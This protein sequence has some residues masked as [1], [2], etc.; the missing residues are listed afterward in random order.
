[1]RDAAI[2]FA[3]SAEYSQYFPHTKNLGQSALIEPRLRILFCL[4][5]LSFYRL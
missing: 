5:Y 3:E 1:M 2:F 4:V